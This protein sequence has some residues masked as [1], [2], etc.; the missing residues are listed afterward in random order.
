VITHTLNIA[1]SYILI[2]GKLGLPAMEVRGAALGAVLARIVEIGIMLGFM[3]LGD[4]RIRFKIKYLLSKNLTVGMTLLRGDFFKLLR[5]LMGH[6]IVWSFGMT[7]TQA[8][9]GQ[10]STSA[11]AAFNVC[12]VLYE[13]AIA[14]LNGMSGAA[15]TLIGKAVGKGQRPEV[16]QQ[17]YTLMLIGTVFGV[18]GALLLLFGGGA[19]SSLYAL[20]PQSLG[21]VK[22]IMPIMAGVVFF[23]AWEVIGL[24]G[25]LR[26][27]GDAKTGFYTDCVVMWCIAIPLGLVASLVFDL[28]PVFVILILKMDMPLKGA[29][30]LIRVLRMRWV[31]DM[32]RDH[33]AKLAET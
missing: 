17:A 26:G 4:S 19:F 6:E 29:V 31:T 14:P 5:P 20:S 23:S 21:Y 22:S 16:K 2:F 15:T 7:A 3:H 18:G 27:G 11:I 13:I 33:T 28:H 1:F 30:G 25:V 24:V 32:T 10:I 9:M 8:I 12:Y